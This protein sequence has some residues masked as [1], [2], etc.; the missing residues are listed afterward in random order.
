MN[1]WF[2]PPHGGADDYATAAFSM[3]Q[4]RAGRMMNSHNGLAAVIRQF[5]AGNSGNFTR[6]R[7]AVRD[8]A[9][10]CT[11]GYCRR[12]ISSQLQQSRRCD[13]A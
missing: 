2:F 9:G 8:E 4:A 7:S 3:L 1:G 11:P 6:P 10:L 12:S 13:A 5:S